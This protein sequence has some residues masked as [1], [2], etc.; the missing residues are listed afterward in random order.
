MTALK[1]LTP[2]QELSPLETCL[3][4]V[5]AHLDR[6]LTVGALHAAQSGTTGHLTPRDAIE[7]ARHAGLQ[8]GFGS[9]KLADFDDSLVPAIFLLED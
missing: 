9:R 2:R 3:M 8:A 5:A 1:P 6:S 4:H 7:V